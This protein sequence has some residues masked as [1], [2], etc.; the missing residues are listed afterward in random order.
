MPRT[1]QEG[2]AL[3]MVVL[4]LFA[5]AVAGA[6]GYQIVTAEHE[7]AGG[8]EQKE[9]AL[10]LARAGLERYVGEHIGVPTVSTWMEASGGTVTVTPRRL[11]DADDVDPEEEFD[12]YLLDSV[13]EMPDPRYPNSPALR[14]VRQYA[15][16]HRMPVNAVAAMMSIATQVRLDSDGDLDVTPGN[17]ICGYGPSVRGLAN[18]GTYVQNGGDLNDG[19]IQLG[20]FQALMDS[21]EARWSV[22]TDPTFTIPFYDDVWPTSFPNNVFPVIR[23]NG[24]L[25]AGGAHDG[26]GVLIVTGNFTV[27]PNFDWTGIILA[28]RSSSLDANG[29]DAEIDGMLV[30][31]LN[32]A[33]QAQLVVADLE[34]DFDCSDVQDAN[35]SLAYLE[36]ADNTRWEF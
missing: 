22:L 4:L 8:G 28:G 34:I 18:V 16:L 35:L 6:T 24:D 14:T 15:V 21:L 25:N 26:R 1:N 32:G 3:V 2:F 36:L 17:S 7:L 29:S 9:E 33:S 27:A 13:G 23:V 11:S 10:A 30:T 20:S 19:H 5:V 31:G 12:V